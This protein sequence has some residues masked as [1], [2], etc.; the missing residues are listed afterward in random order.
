MGPQLGV[1]NKCSAPKT[2]HRAQPNHIDLM[3][4]MAGDE[5]KNFGWEAIDRNKRVPPLVDT[6]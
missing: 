5:G 3:G 1:M 6:R 2:A 4:E